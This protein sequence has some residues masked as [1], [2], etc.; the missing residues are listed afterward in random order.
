MTVSELISI[1]Q[2]LPQD[3]EI[4]NGSVEYHKE[5]DGL[6]V[7]TLYNFEAVYYPKVRSCRSS[8]PSWNSVHENVVILEYI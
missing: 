5:A 8:L 6:P 4:F 2:V 1:L 7:F 3:A